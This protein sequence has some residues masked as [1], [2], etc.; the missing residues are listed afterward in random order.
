VQMPV[1]R[2][3]DGQFGD[4]LICHVAPITRLQ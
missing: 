1:V 4:L 2:A 3:A